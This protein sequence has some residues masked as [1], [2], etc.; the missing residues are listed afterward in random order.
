MTEPGSQLHGDAVRAIGVD[1]GGTKLSVGLVTPSGV[2][3]GSVRTRPT[4]AA[5]GPDAI[6]E[7]VASLVTELAAEADAMTPVGVGTAGV[8]DAHGTVLSAT[9]AIADWAGF[10]LHTALTARL[11]RPVTVLNDVHAAA[12]G[13]A[14]LGAGRDRNGFLMVTVGTGVG[15]ALWLD[16]ALHTGRTGTAG[17]LGHTAAR[18]LDG[19][20]GPGSVGVR[21]CT[22]G[23]RGHIEAY[24]S[25]PAMERAYGELTGRALTL[26]RIAARLDDD[27]DAAAVLESGAAVLGTGIAD[28]LNL[29]DVDAV[30]VGGGVASI[31]PRYLTQVADAMA[32]AALPGPANV[33]LLAAGLGT[34]A[35]LVGAALHA[36]EHCAE[37]PRQEDPR[38]DAG[39]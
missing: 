25:G 14:R 15:G 5:S 37:A 21:E 28:A 22:C 26:R 13:E 19:E 17:S 20:R 18:W 29:L 10:E 35:T 27:P 6:V 12:V 16:G 24:A 34:D 2:V 30:L 3:A 36:A 4:P 33:P 39:R 32:R 7:A 11:G 8:I 31:G 23:Q 1:I 38:G 9:D